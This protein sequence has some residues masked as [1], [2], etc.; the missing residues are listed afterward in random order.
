VQKYE[1]RG[2]IQI[3]STLHEAVDSFED[4]EKKFNKM[5]AN[6]FIKN[7]YMCLE[8]VIKIR[9]IVN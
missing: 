6:S 4:F 7:I 2:L 1:C 5:K 9:P 8:I 3:L